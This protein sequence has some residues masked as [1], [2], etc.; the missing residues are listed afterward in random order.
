MIALASSV[1][2]ASAE[3]SSIA[4]MMPEDKEKLTFKHQRFIAIMEN[5]LVLTVWKIAPIKRSSVFAL[6]GI[7]FTYTLMFYTLGPV[8]RD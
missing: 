7:I 2:E 6:A 3:V 4:L 1:P 5:E 8:K